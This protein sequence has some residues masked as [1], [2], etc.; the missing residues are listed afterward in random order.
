MRKIDLDF[1]KATIE[2]RAEINT[3]ISAKEHDDELNEDYICLECLNKLTGLYEGYAFIYEYGLLD[4]NYGSDHLLERMQE[5]ED[6][7]SYEILVDIIIE[8]IR[9][10]FFN[11]RSF[12]SDMMESLGLSEIN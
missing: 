4:M 5:S 10:D 8:D 7:N 12:M 11:E 3:V 1:L 2:R 6:E 9:Q